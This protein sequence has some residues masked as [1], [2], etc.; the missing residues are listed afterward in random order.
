[1]AS[2]GQLNSKDLRTIIGVPMLIATANAI[3]RLIAAAA[4]DGITL[5]SWAGY[6]GYRSIALQRL[7]KTTNNPAAYGM[8]A[9]TQK[10]LSAVGASPHGLGRAIDFKPGTLNRSRT[11]LVKNAPRFGFSRP[12]ATNDPNHWVHDGKTGITPMATATQRVTATAVNKRSLPVISTST[13]KGAVQKGI[14]VDMKG[15]VVAPAPKGSTNTIWY[16]GKDGFYYWSGAFTTQSTASLSNLVPV[17]TPPVVTPPATTLTQADIEAIANAVVVKVK[18]LIPTVT[19][20]VSAVWAKLL[21]QF[22]K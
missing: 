6:G 9:K 19:D 15:Y 3:E 10:L 4:K 16:V 11:W 1:M 12:M 20:I 2:N 8:S 14:V 17:V 5:T 21:A 18:P 7:M 22:T 13:D